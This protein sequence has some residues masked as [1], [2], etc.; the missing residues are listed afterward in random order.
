MEIDTDHLKITHDIMTVHEVANYLRLCEA[1]IYQM[2]RTGRIPVYHMGRVW[3][4]KRA[5]IDTWLNSSENKNDR[6]I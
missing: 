3:R 2:A 6:V 1:T 4:F 5:D